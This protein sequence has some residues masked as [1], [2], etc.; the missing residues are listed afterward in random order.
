MLR[1]GSMERTIFVLSFLTGIVGSKICLTFIIERGKKF[2][3]TKYY[4][5]MIKSLGLILMFFGLILLKDGIGY[6]LR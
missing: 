4:L 2:V 5:R 1:G 3:E 6:L